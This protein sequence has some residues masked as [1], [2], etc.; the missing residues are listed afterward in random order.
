MKKLVLTLAG[1]LCLT[2]LA[3]AA[4]TYWTDTNPTLSA[5]D[6]IGAMNALLAADRMPA[7]D[8]QLVK[9]FNAGAAIV[10][11]ETVKNQD[12]STTY[13][14]RAA[15]HPLMGGPTGRLFIRV[16]TAC[17]DGPAPADG[18]R[19]HNVYSAGQAADSN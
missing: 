8:A 4:E 3:Q 19:C 12:G 17:S 10:S 13:F 2:T 6:A 16:S 5:Q 14:Y 18:G 7:Q 15:R 11:I 9:Q 1:M